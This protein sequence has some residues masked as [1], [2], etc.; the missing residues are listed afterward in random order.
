MSENINSFEDFHKALMKFS[1]KVVIFRGVTDAKEYKLI[2]KLGRIKFKAKSGI[3][4]QEKELLR[5]FRERL[6]PYLEFVPSNEWEWL[7]L[8]NH[9]GLPT[10]L[11]DWTR[12][13]LVAAYFA[14]EKPHNG[15]SLSMYTKVQNT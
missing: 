11:L 1:G 5:L 10:R 15:D 4:T 8:A 2:P 9:H 6:R 7:A 14:V 13:P 12:N 3:I